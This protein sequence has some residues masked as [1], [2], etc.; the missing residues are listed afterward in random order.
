MQILDYN[1]FFHFHSWARQLPIRI[2]IEEIQSEVLNKNDMVYQKEIYVCA[3]F[4]TFG[5]SG[6]P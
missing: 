1:F 3:V 2:L 5:L 4:D 6:V